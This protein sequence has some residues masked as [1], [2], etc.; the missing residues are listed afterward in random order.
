ML[1]PVTDRGRFWSTTFYR[2]L[3]PE[4]FTGDEP[5]R[6]WCPECGEPVTRVMSNKESRPL[7]NG[8]IAAREGRDDDP[9]ARALRRYHGGTIEEILTALAGIPPSMWSEYVCHFRHLPN[10]G[11]CWL[12]REDVTARE[13]AGSADTERLRL[14]P[15]ERALRLAMNAS[16]TAWSGET[17]HYGGR[18]SD[19]SYARKLPLEQVDHNAFDIDKAKV[20]VEHKACAVFNERHA[21]TGFAPLTLIDP[22]KRSDR[23]VRVAEQL[24]SAGR[25]EEFKTTPTSMRMAAHIRSVG[26]PFASTFALGRVAARGFRAVLLFGYAK[27]FGMVPVENNGAFFNRHSELATLVREAGW[28]R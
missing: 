7:V 3:H 4:N 17:L 8:L 27:G 19:G 28:A 23:V 16:C 18:E 10:G 5:D 6:L 24:L 2:W 1:Y 12:R 13:W 26:F 11:E 21:F 9:S 22:I 14:V 20:M 15:R 25:F